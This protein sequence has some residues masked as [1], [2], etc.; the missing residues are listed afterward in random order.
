MMQLQT[1][2]LSG[3]PCKF[4]YCHTLSTQINKRTNQTII[5]VSC[6]HRIPNLAVSFRKWRSSAS[7]GSRR[8][9]TCSRGSTCPRPT[10]G[11]TSSTPSTSSSGPSTGG[12]SRRVSR[13][14]P[15]C[16]SDHSPMTSLPSCFMRISFFFS[17]KKRFENDPRRSKTVQ[18]PWPPWRLPAP[19]DK[20]MEDPRK[21][22]HSSEQLNN[23]V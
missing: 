12:T 13:D 6:P 3:T 5:R 22:L 15:L 16:E 19:V 21:L 11:R 1:V 9:A 10:S 14:S 20:G 23:A 4:S 2:I 7:R 17:A 18:S 8:A